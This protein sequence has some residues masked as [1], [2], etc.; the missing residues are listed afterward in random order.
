[1]SSS[2]TLGEGK[3]EPLLAGKDEYRIVMCP[4]GGELNVYDDGAV[5]VVEEAKMYGFRLPLGVRL[6]HDSSSPLALAEQPMSDDPTPAG[7]HLPTRVPLQRSATPAS[8]SAAGES[9][10]QISDCPF[11]GN[12]A[13][14][15]GRHLFFVI[16]TG[17][18]C[19]G[20]YEPA[21]QISN[22][23][24]AIRQWNRRADRAAAAGRVEALQLEL[25][26]VKWQMLDY[27][28]SYNEAIGE[29]EQLEAELVWRR[30]QSSLNHDDYL[31][32]LGADY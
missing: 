12:E 28:R 23:Q 20:A 8:L 6:W 24:D 30:Q 10:L 31:R 17:G 32:S 27:Q 3:W 14:L 16:C 22:A 1:M 11:C 26:E 2:N 13:I 9:G 29:R 21:V 18:N 5:V 19:R 15:K 4:Q 7:P 25:T